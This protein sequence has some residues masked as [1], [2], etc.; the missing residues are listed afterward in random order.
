MQ[1]RCLARASTGTLEGLIVDD[2]Q[3]Y[4]VEERENDVKRQNKENDTQKT[5]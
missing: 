4:I 2:W 3:Y 5:N 1:S